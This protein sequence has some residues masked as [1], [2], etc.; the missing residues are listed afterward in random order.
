MR[1]NT[2][3]TVHINNEGDHFLVSSSDCPL[4]LFRQPQIKR[5]SVEGSHYWILTFPGI[6][7]R[8]ITPSEAFVSETP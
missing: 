4:Y 8:S 2:F 1:S 7:H 3:L 6:S 5:Y